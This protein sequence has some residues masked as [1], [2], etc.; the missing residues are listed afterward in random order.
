MEPQSRDA[1]WRSSIRNNS[2]GIQTFRLEA[3][4]EGLEFLPPKT[5]ISIGGDRRATVELRVFAKEGATRRARLEAAG[6][7]RGAMLELPM[8]CC[9]CRADAPSP[10]PPIWMATARPSGCSNRSKARAVFST[11]DGGRWMEFTWKDGNVN[12][13]PEQGVFARRRPGGSA[14]EPATRWSSP[15]A[16]GSGQ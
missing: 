16:A 2:P 5:E 6:H 11:Q 12:F 8:R 13:L 9:C 14:R 1:T 3:A 7:G 10:G 4:G 15:A